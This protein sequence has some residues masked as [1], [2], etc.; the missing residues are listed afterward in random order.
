MAA[1]VRGMCY[2]EKA[3]NASVRGMCSRVTMMSCEDETHSL[4]GLDLN[5]TAP[6]GCDGK[7]TIS[8]Q[9]TMYAPFRH[10]RI[11]DVNLT[12]RHRDVAFLV[13]VASASSHSFQESRDVP[14]KVHVCVA[15][16][17]SIITARA[18]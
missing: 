10:R 2:T 15:C 14:P 17:H 4:P 3:P 18:S 12:P 11:L 5:E 6:L 1:L 8:S 9:R 16:M 7:R 13:V